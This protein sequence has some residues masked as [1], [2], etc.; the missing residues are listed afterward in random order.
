MLFSS[1]PEPSAFM[2]FDDVGFLQRTVESAWSAVRF[3]VD[4]ENSTEAKSLRQRLVQGILRVVEKGERNP[5]RI[6][7][8]VLAD[9]PPMTARYGAVA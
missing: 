7:D 2:D 4:D 9:L 1:P 5:V 6:V 8:A 3:A